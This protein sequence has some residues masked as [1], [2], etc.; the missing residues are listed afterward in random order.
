MDLRPAA[1][2]RLARLDHED[3][4]QTGV[5]QARPPGQSVQLQRVWTEIYRNTGTHVIGIS[6][7]YVAIAASGSCPRRYAE[8]QRF[9]CTAATVETEF[10]PAQREVERPIDRHM[11]EDK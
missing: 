4:Y 1:L 10:V 2:D 9:T 11:V 8:E 5:I 3:V 6:G 7:T